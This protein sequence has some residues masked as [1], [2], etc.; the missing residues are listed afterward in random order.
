MP[1]RAP[2][3]ARAVGA[4]RPPRARAT[5]HRVAPARAMRR[6]LAR[7]LATTTAAAAG[8]R[9]T[10]RDGATRARDAWRAPATTRADLSTRASASDAERAARTGR[11]TTTTTTRAASSDAAG[12]DAA[13]AASTANDADGRPEERAGGKGGNWGE[14]SGRKP[15]RVARTESIEGEVFRPRERLKTNAD[16]DRVKR[17]G[18]TYNG[19][20]LRIRAVDNA[21][22]EP[23]TCTR[24]GIVVPKKQVKR[25][26]DRN[27][28]KRRIRH[29]FRTNKDAWPARV[30]FIVFV[31]ASALEGGFEGVRDDMFA[32]SREYAARGEQSRATKSFKDAKR[33]RAEKFRASSDAVNA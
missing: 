8:R 1:T 30:D 14:M 19:A 25:A 10:T 16:F 21:N 18:R 27:L 23:A 12:D 3:L 31:N 26:V 33:R 2:S 29:A 13:A 15:A 22:H 9:A 17:E 4:P 20:H 28:I 7:A 32:W 6:A 24:I 5:T 11:G